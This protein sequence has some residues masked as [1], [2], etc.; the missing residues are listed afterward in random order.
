M[1]DA[2]FKKIETIKLWTKWTLQRKELVV[3][4][5]LW[6]WAITNFY[7]NLA[8]MMNEEMIVCN[9]YQWCLS[10]KSGVWCTILHRIITFQNTAWK[11][12]IKILYHDIMTKASY[13]WK[14]SVRTDII[15]SSQNVNIWVYL[16]LA[17]K[18]SY[19]II[20]YVYNTKYH[21]Y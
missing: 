9:Q 15:M 17:K 3:V 13:S 21:Y 5:I 2:L 18:Q 10:I 14:R 19:T 6:M 12:S 20:Q 16:Q 4:L 11:L 7:I 1:N 8:M